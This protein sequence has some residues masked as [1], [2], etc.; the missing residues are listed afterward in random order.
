MMLPE[1]NEYCSRVDM[2]HG[3]WAWCGL[4]N[5]ELLSRFERSFTLSRW[6]D[7]EKTSEHADHTWRLCDIAELDLKKKAM[8]KTLTST[9][10]TTLGQLSKK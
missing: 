6:N 7:H 9:E 10:Q 4:C 2:V 8:G 5:K 1:T 3:L